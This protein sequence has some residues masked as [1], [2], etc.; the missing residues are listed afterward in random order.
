[1]LKL[2]RKRNARQADASWQAPPT[3]DSPRAT[4]ERAHVLVRLRGD[5]QTALPAVDGVTR[6]SATAVRL[7]HSAMSPGVASISFERVFDAQ[8]TPLA[9]MFDQSLASAVARCTEG[10]SASLVLAGAPGSGKS[11]A[12][13]GDRQQHT[14][15][16]IT[17]ALRHVFRELDALRGTR[18]SQLLA[19]L[20]TAQ[21]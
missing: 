17:L 12:C 21:H 16:L 1:M 11:F 3:M 10:F 5:P 7:E 9:H 6:T 20:A 8:H 14:T 13:H 4:M 19:T 2:A 18:T 15:G